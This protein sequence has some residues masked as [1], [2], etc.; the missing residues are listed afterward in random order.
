M[1]VRNKDRREFLMLAHR[2]DSRKHH[3]ANW[4][5]SEKKDGIRCFWDGGI[6]RGLPAI[7]VPYANVTK[8]ARLINESIATGL[9]SRYGKVIHAPTWWLDCLPAILLDGELWIDRGM[10]QQTSSI[11]KQHNPDPIHWQQ[12]K[13]AIID[14]PPIVQIFKDGLIK[15]T[16][17]EKRIIHCVKWVTENGASEL[18][19]VPLGAY[20]SVSQMQKF[21]ISIL[22]DTRV[23]FPIQQE[24]IPS[25]TKLALDFVN[26]RLLDINTIKGE[27]V[28]LRR[29]NGMWTPERTH[30][31]LKVKSYPDDEATV[32]GYTAGRETDKGSKLLGLMGALIVMFNGK[33]FE[34]SGF[35]D[36]ERTF[37]SEDARL[38][39]EQHPGQ[40]M[41]DWVINPDFPK[42]SQVTFKYR[43]LTNDGIPK[44]AH[45]FRKKEDI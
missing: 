18:E 20:V 7:E 1:A 14:S 12:I 17:F 34:L 5:L 3:V 35:T 11:I 23:T 38:Y 6:S 8:D 33:V 29:P 28:I 37:L 15:N 19:P 43:E 24:I 41:P 36:E 40:C 45:Y 44:E 10:M 26:R 32:I 39:A 2:Y 16:V 42:G 25:T 21:L 30:D 31:L 27:G 22:K 9:W 13:Y 4:L